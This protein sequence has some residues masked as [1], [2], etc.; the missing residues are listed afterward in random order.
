MDFVAFT[1]LVC[2]EC[3]GDE[4]VRTMGLSSR[5]GSGTIEILRG[6]QCVHCHHLADLSRMQN[7]VQ[8]KRLETQ[9]LQ[10]QAELKALVGP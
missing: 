3:Q 1:P 10:K 2:A 4:F 5:E 7:E 8:I 9:L 6:Y